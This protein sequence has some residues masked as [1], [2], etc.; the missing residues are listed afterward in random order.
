M[1]VREGERVRLHGGGWF[2]S[3]KRF[4]C[5]SV[6]CIY[7]IQICRPVSM[8]AS[9]ASL[10]FRSLWGGVGLGAA[11]WYLGQRLNLLSTGLCV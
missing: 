9:Y 2:G 7:C 5:L 11:R 10:S 8:Q 6:G 1:C 3:S 4:E